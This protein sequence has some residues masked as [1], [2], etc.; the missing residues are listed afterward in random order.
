[1]HQEHKAVVAGSGNQVGTPISTATHML[2][3][4]TSLHRS[5]ITVAAKLSAYRVVIS[6]HFIQFGKP[7]LCGNSHGAIT[8]MACRF[9][10]IN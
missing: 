4:A 3:L 10:Q 8:A 5:S 1:M 6:T 2:G 9:L 7:G